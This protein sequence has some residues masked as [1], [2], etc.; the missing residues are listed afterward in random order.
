[1]NKTL[2][3]RLVAVPY[4]G[5]APMMQALVADEVQLAIGSSA[6]A[7]QLLKADKLKALAFA[8]S[9]R[10]AEFRDV[11]TT[12]EQGVPDL[13]AFVW[14]AIAAPAGTPADIV[15]RINADM[16]EI[17]SVPAFAERFVTGMGFGVIAGSPSDMDAAIQRELPLIRAM[18]T[19]AG[20]KAQ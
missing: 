2:G 8:S 7:G 5:V 6:I 4:K 17:L 14:F 9:P 19:N 3:T 12:I 1:M 16:R 15:G 13:Q 18:S 20:V 10:H 11:S